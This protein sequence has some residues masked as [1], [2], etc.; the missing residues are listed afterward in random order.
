MSKRIPLSLALILCITCISLAFPDNNCLSFV[1]VPSDYNGQAIS[2]PGA[3]DGSLTINV[4]S[5]AEP[6]E[7]LWDN[8]TTSATRSN[9]GAGTYNVTISDAAGCSINASISL[10]DPTPI[11]ITHNVI[12]PVSCINSADGVLQASATG[13]AGSYSFQ[14]NNGPQT[15][16]NENLACGNYGVTVTDANGC[17]EDDFHIL[18]CPPPMNV[19]ITPT[20]DYNGYHV[21]CPETNG[22][23]AEVTVS[24]GAD[25]YTYAWSSGED[26]DIAQ[27]LSGGINSLTVTDAVG[28]SIISFV[29]LNTPPTMNL[30]P[31]VISD[32]EGAAVS[33]IDATDGEVLVGVMNG[34]APYNFQWENGQSQAL[35]T[36]LSAGSNAVTVTDASG[37]Q[38]TEEIDLTVYEI[39]MTPEIISDYNGA[40]ISCHGASDGIVRMNVEAGASSPANVIY[41]WNTGQTTDLLSNIPAGTYTLTVTSPFG[42]S[43]TKEVT[44]EQPDQMAAQATA[45]S[46]YNGYHISINGLSNGA[47]NV[48]PSGGTAPYYFLWENGATTEDTQNL[49]SGI[50]AVSIT[51]ANG[52][53]T[54]A[55]VELNEP[56]VLDGFADVLSDYHGQDISCFGEEDGRAIAIASGAVPPYTFDWSNSTAGD[57][58][59]NLSAGNHQVTITDLN[60]ATFVTE[61]T[62][63]EPQPIEV[64]INSNASTYPP[65]GTAKAAAT[66]GTPPFQYSWDDPF[67]RATEE[68][69]QLEPGWYRVTV[70]DANGCKAMEIVEIELSNE[71]DCIKKNITITPNDDGRNDYLTLG[72]IQP[73]NNTVEIFDRWGNQVFSRNNYEGDWNGLKKNRAV[74]DGGYFYIISVALPTG[75]RTFK[76]SITIIR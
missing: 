44:V 66:G 38:I 45:T 27:N 53:I 36:S 33:C 4:L 20:S 34:T 40:T 12:D 58:T 75:K 57:S 26:A 59:E 2:C 73:F 16:L 22:G 29:E 31:N 6:Y 5:G 76:G 25:P 13:G 7:F 64:S 24:L 14:W 49:P 32:F 21:T 50:Q 54:S 55:Q 63:T 43:S 1:F 70:T 8:G 11:S 9:L 62:L 17:S 37:C 41:Q 30:I 39:N 19:S 65:S 18:S 3:E 42:C 56:T 10:Q 74:P 60:G 52:C 35:A 47:A 15:S 61:V 46:D 68:I 48:L 71:L 23:A 69:D 28:C 72:C 67:L 51:D